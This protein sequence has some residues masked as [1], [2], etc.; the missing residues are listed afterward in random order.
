MKYLKKFFAFLLIFCL[1]VPI[2]HSKGGKA[3]SMGSKSG[4]ASISASKTIPSEPTNTN[5]Q[6]GVNSKVTPTPNTPKAVKNTSTQK[7]SAA[8]REKIKAKLNEKVQILKEKRNVEQRVGIKLRFDSKSNSYVTPAGIKYKLTD[9][10]HGNRI[11]HVLSHTKP[12]LT[13]SRHTVFNVSEKQALSLID[14]AWKQ[15]GS[16]LNSDKRVYL[17]DM[18]RIIGT[19]GEKIIRIVVSSPGS[20][21]IL[22]AYPQ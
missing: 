6:N 12:D 2:V 10:R 1:T 14:S 20:S 3:G 5:V 8:S 19:Q 13:K 9:A 22:T 4:T 21:E 7:W 17:V 15:K 18:G 11:N 16:P